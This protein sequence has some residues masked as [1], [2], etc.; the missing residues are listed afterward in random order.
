MLIKHNDY[1]SKFVC[2]FE[3]LHKHRIKKI[4]E[5]FNVYS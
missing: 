5:S 3:L 1:N 4:Y 2:L